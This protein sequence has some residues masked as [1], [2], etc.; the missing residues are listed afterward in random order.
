[1]KGHL[2]PCSGVDPCQAT[3]STLT[4]MSSIASPH[5]SGSGNQGLE[6]VRILACSS[7]T[8]TIP[9]LA[10]IHLPPHSHCCLIPLP[11][12]PILFPFCL[13]PICCTGAL[14]QQSATCSSGQAILNDLLHFVSVAKGLMVSECSFHWCNPN[15]QRIGP[16]V[17]YFLVNLLVRL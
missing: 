13:P 16:F 11:P 10:F 3:G 6:G 12:Y 15:P 1:M 14:S 2:L 7:A 5:G 4:C 9:I 17:P 8:N